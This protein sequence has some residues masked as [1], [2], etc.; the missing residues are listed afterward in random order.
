MASSPP[1][2]R[3]L[4]PR[5]PA[6]RWPLPALLA[7]AAGW[8]AMLALL[9]TAALPP[10]LAVAAGMAVAA[11]PALFAVVFYL[12]GSAIEFEPNGPFEFE[13]SVAAL[14]LWSVAY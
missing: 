4:A 2:R 8:V 12:S 9:R 1:L 10:A 13:G 5:L 14:S 11:A 3:P 7:W 6:L